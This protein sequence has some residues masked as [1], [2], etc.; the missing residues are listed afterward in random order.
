[1]R[2]RTSLFDVLNMIR[3]ILCLRGRTP[4][5]ENS[6][7]WEH[8][9]SDNAYKFHNNLSLSLS[10]NTK[11]SSSNFSLLSDLFPKSTF[12]IAFAISS[13]L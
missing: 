7:F 9:K 2:E 1:M 5:T 13:G 11:L 6:A 3:Y 10:L 8:R 4:E 12:N